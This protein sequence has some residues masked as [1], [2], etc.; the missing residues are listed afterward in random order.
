M[1]ANSSASSIG[2]LS[3]EARTNVAA[4]STT[5][6]WTSYAGRLEA[7]NDI[8][9]TDHAALTCHDVVV[10]PEELVVGTPANGLFV[11]QE[12]S[13]YEGIGLITVFLGF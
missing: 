3:F 2:Y 5:D 1:S 12:C 4:T 9:V 13:G 11:D 6:C 8:S 10:I 7:P